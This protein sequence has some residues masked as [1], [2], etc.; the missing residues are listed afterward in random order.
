MIEVRFY[1]KDIVE[2]TL[3]LDD[4]TDKEVINGKFIEW[5][6]EQLSGFYIYKEFSAGWSR[7]D[8]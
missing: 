4:E 6:Q 5:V 1:I 8:D 2:E 7:L 3:F